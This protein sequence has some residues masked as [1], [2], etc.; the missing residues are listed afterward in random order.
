VITPWNDPFPAAAGLLAAA[1]VTGNTVVHKPSERSARPGWEMARL[2]A[3]ALPAGVLNVVTGDGETG[4]AL[5]ADDRVALV[6]HVGSTAAGRS[7]AAAAGSRG[8][9]VLLE[10]GGKDPLLVDAG[11]D[12]VWAAGQIALGAFVNT[13]QLCTSVERVYLHADVADDVLA[14]LVEIATDLAVGDPADPVTRIGPMVDADQLAVVD[15]QVRGAM[16]AGARCLVGGAPLDRP[17]SWY[18]PTVLDGCPH[19]VELLTEETFGPVAA[20]TRVPTFE[21]GLRLAGSGRYGLAAT[22][23]TPDL[24]HALRAVDELEVGTVKVNA[25]FGG[26]PGGSADPRRDSG[27]GAGY[28]PDLLAAMTVLK[29]VHLE[30]APRG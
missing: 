23:L 15:R 8:A 13:G 17:G 2:I 16:A 9:R 14:A 5:V 7:I 26:A 4:R 22:V 24:E 10:N 20:V 21:E 27:A 28:G 30:A 11:V 19:D 29:A 1:L 3:E 12:P 6:A 25:V 18:P